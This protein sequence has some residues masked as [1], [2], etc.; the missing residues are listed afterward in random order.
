LTKHLDETKANL[1]KIV[2]EFTVNPDATLGRIEKG[3]QV[4][5]RSL[6]VMPTLS[7]HSRENLSAAYTQ[8]MKL[9]VKG[10]SE[11]SI[12]AMRDAVEQNANKGYRFASLTEGIKHQFGVS[13]SKAKFLARQETSL[14]MSNYRKERFT[15]AG[16]GLFKW[17]TSHDV[18]V[19]HDHRSLDGRVF[20]YNDPPIVDKATGKRGTPGTDFNCRC[21]DIPIVGSRKVFE[22]AFS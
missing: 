6:T 20:A 18:R 9:W 10:W 15:A 2:D 14:F 17:S 5:A 11:D 13:Q 21:V 16:I 7:A 19:R 8:N 12:E 4:A 3:F 22:E 1:D